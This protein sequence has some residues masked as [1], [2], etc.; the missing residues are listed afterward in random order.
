MRNKLR[1]RARL[2]LYNI[3]KTQNIYVEYK[4]T[5]EN[6]QENKIYTR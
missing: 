1:I 3:I 2:I 6:H 5:P 4:N